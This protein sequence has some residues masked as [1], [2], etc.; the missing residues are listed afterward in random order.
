[1]DELLPSGSIEEIDPLLH[2]LIRVEAERQHRKLILIASESIC[3]PA[4]RAALS[5][6]FSH[7]YAEGYP[8]P[9]TLL[10]PPAQLESFAY[11]LAT[12][13]RLSNRR[14]Y[15]GCEYVDFLEQVL[16]RR[17]AEVFANDLEPAEN[18]FVNAQPLSGAAANNAVYNAFVKPG[19][20]VMGPSLTHGGHLTHG[21]EVNRS[22]MNFR[23]VA[24]EIA[25]SGQIDYDAV[26]KLAQEHKP[27]LIIGGFSAY[28]WDIDWE[29]MRAIADGIGAILL[30]DIA[31]L[32]GLVAGGVLN[33]PIGHAHVVS[34]TT[35]KTLCGPRGA[36][37]LSTD[38]EIAAKVDMGVFP[39]EQGGPHIHVLAAKA[40]AMKIAASAGF[41][42][43]Q[44]GVQENARAL[45]DGFVEQGLSLAYGGTNT[46]MCLV[47][48]R[49][50]ECPSG[51][52]L[53]GEIAARL[54]DLAGIVCN[55]NTIHGD[56][57]A[58]HPSGL[59][60][61][62]TW[63]TQRGLG[64]DHMRRLAVLV[65]KLLSQIHPFGYIGGQIDL[66][67][68][69]KN[70]S[71][72]EEL[73]GE[74]DALVAEAADEPGFDPEAPRSGYPHFSPAASEGTRET[75]LAPLHKSQAVK[76]VEKDGFFIPAHYGDP[77]REKSAITSGTALVD[78]GGEL[79]LEISQARAGQ[80]LECA[81]ASQVLSLGEWES[82]P[83]LLLNQA[84]ET[85]ARALVLRLPVDDTGGARYWLKARTD[86]ADGLLAWLRGLSD[87]YVLHDDDLW[88]KAEGPAV[89][90]NLTSPSAGRKA[91]T[92]LGLRGPRADDVIKP[93]FSVQVPAWGQAVQ[94]DDCVI[95][96]R[97]KGTV[98][99]FEVFVPTSKATATWSKLIEAGAQ[100][101]GY[102]A[103][104]AVFAEYR[105]EPEGGDGRVDL[106]KPYFIGQRALLGNAE[107]VEAPKA[108]TFEPEEQE[109][110]KTCLFEEHEKLCEP[111]HLVP[112]AGFK[113]PLMYSGILDEHE[114]VRTK[115][116]LFDVSH[117]GLLEFKGPWAERFLDLVTAN[118]VPLLLP[119]QAHYSYLLADDGRCIDDIIVYRKGPDLFWMVVNAA[120]VDED[121]AWLQA[122]AAGQVL[123][124][125][126]NP[127]ARATGAVKIRDLKD[128]ACGDQ[129]RVDIAFQGPLA[130]RIMSK[131]AEGRDFKLAIERLRKFEL[132]EGKLAD[133][134]VTIA[135]TGYTGEDV[136]F[137]IFVHPEQAV[138]LWNELLDAG[139]PDGA[140]P[141]GLGARDSLRTEAGFPLHGHELAGPH[142][143]TPIESGY[144]KYVRLHKPFFTGRAAMLEGHKKRERTIIRF[145]VDDRGGKVVRLGNPVLAGRKNEYAG[146]LT[147]ATSTGQRQVGLALVESKFAKQGSKIQVLTITP[148]DKKVPPARNPLELQS[149]DWMSVPRQAT[150]LPRFMPPGEQAS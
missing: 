83:A 149:G 75:A 89:I 106:D 52:P 112:F 137:E 61:G 128:P 53:T 131:L 81:C 93:V 136:G 139:K 99:G 78:S 74:V 70:R 30:A 77:E 104:R 20:T 32:A 91:M 92:C 148:D 63:V 103:A 47:D 7:I 85:L 55:K 142:R 126:N 107:P 48:L 147:S 140:M 46:H 135:R 79:L 13:R 100:P 39:G 36:M 14:Y 138:S 96:N 82:A 97:P 11:Q 50:V 67:R 68:G 143:V 49:R 29:R 122:V 1:M 62:T 34:F 15:K 124:D 44:Q 12:Y 72:L 141:A 130:G 110:K 144:G 64:P 33:S 123:L 108:F 150:I 98:P 56:T 115:A 8:S 17:T 65:A 18:I 38:P 80:L 27:K 60:F 132:A 95:L 86:D 41:K 19:D 3:P 116:G 5:S 45:A 121:S 134:Q 22:G 42:K 129:A 127:R 133:K 51:L 105:P 66:G 90:E 26:E 35:H 57:N 145:Q 114:A 40:V 73:T 58:T 76:M 117:M 84:G 54:L 28:P 118:Y 88:L 71:L 25:R 23:I 21:S 109:L 59:R 69:K 10:E 31:H 102:D 101:T 125:P 111:M 87:G 16:R 146:V 43:L 94:V 4:V 2:D 119:G 37:L 9:R 120:N 6:E 24:Y 113:M